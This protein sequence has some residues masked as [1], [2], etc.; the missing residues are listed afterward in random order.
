MYFISCQPAQQ[1][2]QWELEVLL[3]NLQQFNIRTIILL[4]KKEDDRIV[5]Y[6]SAKYPFVRCH[7]Y[8]D[9]RQSKHYISSIRPYLWASFLKEFPDMEKEDYFYVDSDIILREPIDFDA[10]N[11]DSTHWIGSD[12]ESYL[13]PV[14]L[15]SLEYDYLPAMARIVGLSSE[16]IN[17]LNK[18]SA[19]AQWIISKPTQAF[20]QKVYED[21]ESL[22][23]YFSQVEHISKQMNDTS[24][25][26]LIQ[27]WC[28]DMWA[29]LW[30]C[31]YAG[32]EIETSEELNFSWSKNPADAYFKTK[33]LHNAGVTQASSDFFLK[34]DYYET[35]PLDEDLEISD[36]YCS[37]YYVQAIKKVKGKIK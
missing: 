5:E 35:S 7:V 36:N 2:F 15:N 37:Y 30:N 9:F 18:K 29:L 11:F 24:S 34:S 28:A 13:S 26:K 27:K 6:I 16:Q 32:I 23:Y 3:T 25:P 31:V 8:D 17:S 19:G 4:F 33:I 1:R 21:S 22:Y 10:L 12:C 14:Y 20:W